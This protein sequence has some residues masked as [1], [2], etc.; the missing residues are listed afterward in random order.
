MDA[1]PFQASRNAA[2][3]SVHPRSAPVLLAR[4]PLLDDILGQHAQHLG[5]DFVA[6]RNHAY[7]VA[8]FCHV[9]AP[10]SSLDAV[11]I[12]AAF[13]DIGIWTQRTFDYLEPSRKRAQ[14]WL[15][16]NDHDNQGEVIDAMIGQH[17]KVTRYRGAGEALVEPFRR[18]DLADVS[19]GLFAAGIARPFLSEVFGRFPAAG[20]HRLLFRLACRRFV[21]YPLNPLPMMRW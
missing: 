5:T 21:Q 19:A 17:H 12:A 10:A 6:Y 13:H 16:S 1:E 20:F 9:L 18:A 14:E 2:G 4:L 8:N 15:A 11:S 7:R 3:M